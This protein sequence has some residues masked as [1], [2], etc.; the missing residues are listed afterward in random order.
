[1]SG[2]ES[3]PPVL[4]QKNLFNALASLTSNEES[5]RKRLVDKKKFI[6]ELLSGIKSKHPQIKYAA[7]NCFVS[8]SRS[9]RLIKSMILE[10]GDFTKELVSILL[11]NDVDESLELIVCKAICNLALDV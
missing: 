11:G 2:A 10:A 9:D 8:L 7:C 3:S 4:L 5:C 1:M 6:D